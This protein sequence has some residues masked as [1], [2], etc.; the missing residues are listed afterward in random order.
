MAATAQAADSA[1]RTAGAAYFQALHDTVVTTLVVIARGGLDHRAAEVRQRCARDA[2]Y[3]RRLLLDDAPPTDS[4]VTQRL[5][6]AIAAVEGLG[7][8][9]RYRPD[10]APAPVPPAAAE[11]LG[12]ATRAALNNVLIHAGTS[13]CWVTVL[14]SG[15]WCRGRRRPLRPR[16]RAVRRRGAPGQAAHP[17]RRRLPARAVHRLDRTG[18]CGRPDRLRTTDRDQPLS[19]PLLVRRAAVRG[20]RRLPGALPDPGRRRGADPPAGR[21]PAARRRP[22]GRPAGRGRPALVGQGAG[23]APDAR[24]P[25]PQRP[26][27]GVP[28]RQRLGPA[29]AGRRALLARDAPDLRRVRADPRRPGHRRADPRDVPGRHHDRHAQ[30]A[31]DGDH[32]GPRAGP[33]LA[34]LRRGRV[35]RPVPRGPLPDHPR[36]GP[37]RRRGLPAGRWWPRARLRAGPGVRGVPGQAGLQRPRARR[38]AGGPAG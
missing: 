37:V 35:V 23:R 1:R 3:L 29:A 19:L 30:G 25:G 38:D 22:P 21:D 9:V 16:L 15:P 2:D 24:R 10:P 14:R 34:L 5:A 4:D 28:A 11:A 18:H 26:G 20:G 13:V 6:E 31:R 17:G 33:A 32:R 36:G 27:P 8:R 7:L 12:E